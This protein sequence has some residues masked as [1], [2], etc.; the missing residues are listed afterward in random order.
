MTGITAPLEAARSYCYSVRNSRR[1]PSF[2]L[3]NRTMW[4]SSVCVALSTF[5]LESPGLTMWFFP[6]RGW[7]AWMLICWGWSHKAQGQDWDQGH[8]L[9]Q[10]GEPTLEKPL[11]WRPLPW[12]EENLGLVFISAHS[13][14]TPEKESTYHPSWALYKFN[15]SMGRVEGA[16]K[17]D[18]TGFSFTSDLEQVSLDTEAWHSMA[19]SG[20]AWTWQFSSRGCYE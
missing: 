4:F 20:S 2:R 14:T 15:L 13:M 18:V 5:K 3:F 11:R 9:Y 19:C 7:E 17:W 8:W 6:C 10:P 12:M 1:W 16:L